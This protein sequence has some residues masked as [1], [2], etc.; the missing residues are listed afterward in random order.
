MTDFSALSAFINERIC[1]L[2]YPESPAGLYDP[3]K[4]MLDGGGKRLRPLLLLATCEAFCGD[5]R[6]AVP[7]ALGI[8]MYHNFTLLHDDVMDNSDT[9]HGRP[10]VHRRWDVPT[11]ILSGDAMLTMAGDLMMECSDGDLR[12]VMNTFQCVAMDVYKGQQYDMEFETR[13]DV[14]VDEYIDMIRLKTSAL[15]AGACRLGGVMAHASDEDIQYIWNYADCLG[16]AFQLQDDYLDT[17]GDP[18]KFGKPIG[19]DILNEKKTWLLISAKALAPERVG[20][21]MKLGGAE[22]IEAVRNIYKELH[23]DEACKNLVEKYAAKAEKEVGMTSMSAEHKA[24]F[25]ALVNKLSARE[26]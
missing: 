22:R 13:D 24:A 4:Y 3:V 17:F 1:Q 18:G 16:L 2:A 14:S 25:I 8:E 9:R 23:L 26:S 20:G 6:R 21:G 7:Q 5:F 12:R 15:L 19:G 11:A 10:S